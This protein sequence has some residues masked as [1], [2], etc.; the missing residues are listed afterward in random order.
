M[1]DIIIT[2][3]NFLYLILESLPTW[4]SREQ[5]KQYFPE[6]FKGEF[7]DIR[8]II[9]CTEIKCQTLQDLE[10]QSELYSKGKSHN[11]FK[12]LVGISH[13][14]WITFVSSLYGGSILDKEI[15]KRSSLTDLLE[16]NDL[17]MMDHGRSK[18][19]IY[20]IYW[21]ARR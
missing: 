21:H 18:D 11:T 17:I 10:K 5:I 8:C 4:P 3:V 15:V 16:E 6:V 1:S 13:N 12:G 7:E 20:R 2:W 19:L 9:N 14:V